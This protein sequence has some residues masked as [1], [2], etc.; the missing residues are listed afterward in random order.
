M[1]ITS[2]EDVACIKEYGIMGIGCETDEAAQSKIVV[3][4]TVEELLR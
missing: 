3:G 4:L 2:L 1:G